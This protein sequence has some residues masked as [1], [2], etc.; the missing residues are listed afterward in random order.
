[1]ATES[2]YSALCISNIKPINHGNVT[3]MHLRNNHKD[4]Q[5]FQIKGA[6]TMFKQKYLKTD[7]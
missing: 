2:I 7:L 1:M 3:L 6:C 5:E 4:T